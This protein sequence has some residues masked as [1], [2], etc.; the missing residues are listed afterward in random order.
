MSILIKT[1]YDM[2]EKINMVLISFIF[3]CI[4]TFGINATSVNH[5]NE[6]NNANKIELKAD[7]NCI[8]ANYRIGGVCSGA[9]ERLCEGPPE[10]KHPNSDLEVN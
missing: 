1:R 7:G 2:L 10:C 4:I 8:Y 5:S 6:L 3:I 9:T